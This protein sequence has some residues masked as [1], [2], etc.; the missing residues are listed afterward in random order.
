MTNKE[1]KLALTEAI[2]EYLEPISIAVNGTRT[3]LGLPP[4][5]I[6]IRPEIAHQINYFINGFREGA[7]GYYDT[8]YD[9]G[10]KK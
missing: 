10:I 4:V 8:W 2:A 1:L 7:A 9:D 6:S 3:S 5:D